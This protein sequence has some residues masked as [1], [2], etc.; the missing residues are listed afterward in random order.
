MFSRGIF[1]RTNDGRHEDPHGNRDA[2]APWAL[3]DVSADQ[4]HGLKRVEASPY[5]A[6]ADS[7][8]R[9]ISEPA[10]LSETVEE[11]GRADPDLILQLAKLPNGEAKRVL[12]VA[13]R[14]RNR[15]LTHE[16]DVQVATPSLC[17]SML[18]VE[19]FLFSPPM[20]NL[21]QWNLP[22]QCPAEPA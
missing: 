18:T 6:E 20:S 2:F 21:V 14:D 15:S 11:G 10:L 19:R 13:E 8:A 1:S 16:P 3:I 5:E 9:I 7:L 17:N 12:A 22:T 4:L